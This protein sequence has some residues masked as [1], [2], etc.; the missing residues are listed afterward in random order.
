VYDV[1]ALNPGANVT[2]CVFPANVDTPPTT[3]ACAPG[4]RFEHVD[5]PPVAAVQNVKYGVLNGEPPGVAP[6]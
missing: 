2:T 4:L 3:L 1:V 5:V 6:A